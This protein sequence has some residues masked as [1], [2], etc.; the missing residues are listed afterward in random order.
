MICIQSVWLQDVPLRSS[1][2]P[3]PTLSE[4][5]VATTEGFGDKLERVLKA[6]NVAPAI[7]AHLIDQRASGEV[8]LPLRSIGEYHSS[9]RIVV[10]LNVIIVH[11]C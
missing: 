11:V 3:P 2:P 10:L 8:R 1:P 6:L 9:Y 4:S 5:S 7:E